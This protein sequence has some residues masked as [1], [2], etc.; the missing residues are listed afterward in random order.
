MFVIIKRHSCTSWDRLYR[1]DV[2]KEIIDFIKRQGWNFFGIVSRERL[3]DFLE[4]HQKIFKQWISDGNHGTMDWLLRMEE[5]RY[6]P[7]KKLPGLK[8]VI[9]LA[10]QYEYEQIICSKDDGVVAA[11]AAGRDY[12]K[13]LKKKCIELTKWIKFNDKEAQTY[14]SIDS[15]PTPDRVLAEAAGLGF[16]GKNTML[17]SPDKGS[18]FFIASVMT[19]LALVETQNFASLPMPNCGSC[20]KCIDV[21]P[22]GA[23]KGDGS[24]DA[25]LCISYLTIENKEGIPVGLRPKIGNRI[26]GCDICQAVCPFNLKKPKNE[27]VMEGLR[28]E[29]GVG[30]TLDLREVLL[31]ETDEQFLEKFQGTPLMRAKR[32]GML[33]N[34]CVVA[35]NSKN[36][37]LIPFLERV[38]DRETDA[39]LKEHAEWAIE[40]LENRKHQK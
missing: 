19:N 3:Q 12:H 22:T 24:I 21:C 6:H 20:R 13:V 11:Y 10:A 36:R 9:V 7:E 1:M 25:R 14:V 30:H 31:M 23:L 15:G 26:F 2:K 8:S 27:V 18:F 33:R 37:Q 40:R 38:I 17:I 29:V 35:G 32:R 16:F 34:A 4:K 39:M 5:D 28:G